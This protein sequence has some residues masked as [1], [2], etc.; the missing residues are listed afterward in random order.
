MTSAGNGNRMMD[1]GSPLSAIS[2]EE[3]Q[4][5]ATGASSSITVFFY[6]LLKKISNNFLIY[7]LIS[8]FSL[9][10]M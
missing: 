8:L 5:Q 4:L 3:K 1:T 10:L 9:C 7:T 2:S 6:L